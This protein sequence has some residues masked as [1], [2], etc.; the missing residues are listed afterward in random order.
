MGS[1]KPQTVTLP[2]QQQ[3]QQYVSNS[4]APMSIADTP[5]AQAYLDSPIDVD[6]GVGRRTDL[7]EQ[8]LQN[9]WN[10]SFM[11]G[12]P[13]FIRQQQRQSGERQI[14]SQGAAEAQQAEFAKNQQLAA[15]RERLLPQI[16]QTGG[17]QTGSQSGYNTQLVP[18]QSGGLLNS[19]IGGGAA[20]ASRFI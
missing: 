13:A 10:S 11:S 16:V 19:I 2:Q 9:Q 5:E 17:T 1:K 3:S 15:R 8:D 4:F 20:I 14:R 6:P 18:Q 12:V 7:A